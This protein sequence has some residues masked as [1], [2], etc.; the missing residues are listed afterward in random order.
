MKLAIAISIIFL[1]VVVHLIAEEPFESKRDFEVIYTDGPRVTYRYQGLNEDGDGV[2]QLNANDLKEFNKFDKKK[3]EQSRRFFEG[4]EYI[5]GK[6]W[7]DI[8]NYR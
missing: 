8:I 3:R 7:V 2:W 6:G 1:A 4:K 5:D